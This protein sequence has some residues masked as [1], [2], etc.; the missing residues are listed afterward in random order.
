MYRIRSI[1]A[2][3]KKVKSSDFPKTFLRGDR[4][5]TYFTPLHGATPNTQWTHP[6]Q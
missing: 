4:N 1:Q 2:A 3:R 6:L 5:W